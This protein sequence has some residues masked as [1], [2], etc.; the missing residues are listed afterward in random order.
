MKLILTLLLVLLSLATAFG[1]DSLSIRRYDVAI[2][3]LS[4][5]LKQRGDI[6]Y[7][8][9]SLCKKKRR[10]RNYRFDSIYVSPIRIE[11]NYGP[12]LCDILKREYKVKSCVKEL[13]TDS[14]LVQHVTDSLDI[15]KGFEKPTHRYI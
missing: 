13:G 8:L 1:Q 2:D 10:P 12:V 4:R 15:V 11:N 3:S 5:M 14:E 6:N 7:Q 9:Q